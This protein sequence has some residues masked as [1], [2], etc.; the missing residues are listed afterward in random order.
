MKSYLENISASF[1]DIILQFFFI[2][3]V[4]HVSEPYRIVNSACL[5]F[6]LLG[7]I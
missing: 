1:I 4:D 6:S 5:Y 2:L 3:Y 7:D